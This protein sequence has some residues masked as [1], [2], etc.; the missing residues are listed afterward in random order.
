MTVMIVAPMRTHSNLK[1]IPNAGCHPSLGC[2]DLT[3]RIAKIRLMI[4]RMRTP[5]ATKM[6]AA[7]ASL[8]FRGC[9][10]DAIRSMD[11]KIRDTQKTVITLAN[12]FVREHALNTHRR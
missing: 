5:A 6:D 3:R 8:M 2:K 12:A 9:V 10:V 1:M 11:V 4:N 7:I